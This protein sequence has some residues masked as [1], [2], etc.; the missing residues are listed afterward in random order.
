[1][2]RLLQKAESELMKVQKKYNKLATVREFKIYLDWGRD[3]EQCLQL[4]AV[5]HDQPKSM[6]DALLKERQKKQNE[7]YYE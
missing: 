1:M 3:G 5:L 2:S 6:I 4:L 7:R